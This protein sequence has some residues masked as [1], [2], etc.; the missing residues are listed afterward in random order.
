M[1][2]K[3]PDMD[4]QG[5]IQLLVACGNYIQRNDEA[6]QRA[7]PRLFLKTTGSQEEF[8]DLATSNIVKELLQQEVLQVDGHAISFTQ[9]C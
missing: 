2:T 7:K 1:T 5:R 9:T 4:L 6:W 3:H 8:I